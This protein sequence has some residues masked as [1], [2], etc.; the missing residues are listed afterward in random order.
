MY[1]TTGDIYS[2][3]FR[4]YWREFR[5]REKAPQMNDLRLAAFLGHDQILEWI[6]NRDG[7]SNMN[8]ADSSGVTALMRP[9]RGG[10]SAT[11][12][13]YRQCCHGRWLGK[14]RYIAHHGVL[15]T[16]YF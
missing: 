13:Q 10:K 1:D 8:L 9:R 4:I 11:E 16:E 15:R 14:Y 2:H 3:W 7:H 6:V 12:R 5:N